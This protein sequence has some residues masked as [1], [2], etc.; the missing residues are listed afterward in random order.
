MLLLLSIKD[1]GICE[2][3]FYIYHFVVAVKRSLIFGAALV[4]LIKIDGCLRGRETKREGWAVEV[5]HRN[6][7]HTQGVINELRKALLVPNIYLI[8]E[9]SS[10]SS[11]RSPNRR[12]L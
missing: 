8:I 9:G 12:H 4:T 10:S 3:S 1:R 2:K 5:A 7:K 6:D 11:R